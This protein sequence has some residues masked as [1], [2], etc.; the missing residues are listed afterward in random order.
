MEKLGKI[1][2]FMSFNNDT[3][4]KGFIKRFVH[5][6]IPGG[7]VAI[8]DTADTFGF[9]VMEKMFG[10]R[11]R[12]D[13][14]KFLRM[15]T[16]V[17]RYLLHGY[18]NSGR[19]VDIVVPDNG[20]L[21]PEVVASIAGF[22]EYVVVNIQ[23]VCPWAEDV[24]K[25]ADI[26][27]VFVGEDML[28]ALDKV[29]EFVI[30][31]NCLT[32]AVKVVIF[33]DNMNLLNELNVGIKFDIAGILSGNDRRGN[34]NETE[35]VV[36]SI[37]EA[38]KS[39]PGGNAA[40]FGELSSCSIPTVSMTKTITIG[41][42][43]NRVHM[44]LLE[45]EYKKSVH[46]KVLDALK[47]E[48]LEVTSLN[49]RDAA[50][51]NQIVNTVRSVVA[52]GGTHGV[53]LSSSQ[54]EGVIQ[55][56]VND[57]VGYGPLEELMVDKTVSE[58]MVNGIDRIYI[59]RNGKISLAAGVRFEDEQ[60]LRNV[61]D[62]IVA[63]AGRRVDDAVPLADARLFDGSRV[64]VVL[65]PLALNGPVV[66]IRRFMEHKLGV[67]QLVN[68]QSLD[69]NMASF[70]RACV[71]LKKNVV[72]S[73]GTGTGKTTLLNIV[74]S[75][76]PED[77]RIVSIEDSAEL[78]LPHEH[79]VRM[80]A[81]PANVEGKGAVSIRQ[82]VVNALRMR[83]DRIV[84]GECRGGEAFDMLQAMNTGHQGSLSTLHAN[85][86]R[87]ALARLETMVLMAGLDLPSIAIREQIVSAVDIVVQIRRM[88][89]G[90]RKVV[91]ITEVVGIESGT[92][93]TQDIFVYGNNNHVSTGIVPV[94]IDEIKYKCK[95]FDLGVFRDKQAGQVVTEYVIVMLVLLIIGLSAG[96]VFNTAAIKLW[97]MYTT[98]RTGIP[99][100]AP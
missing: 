84:I 58:I 17:S 66:T 82:L 3:R 43:D 47:R 16:E 20:C 73:G 59:E 81:R 100:L 9:S 23:P 48:N 46:N 45:V 61:I 26:L 76:I 36:A 65:P 5:K 51:N 83:P 70:L 32:S 18:F 19:E 4:E 14:S 31:E 30:K 88:A 15:K 8:V 99:G 50:V 86:P 54:R 93:Q 60:H 40:K 63:Q 2:A 87:D 11:E 1:V 79:W 72:I 24:F 33:S 53:S 55:R 7:S 49:L 56:V 35:G 68:I 67:A 91:C 21:L 52:E 25:I 94:F 44:D 12:K 85:T 41:M 95:W 6:L 90:A 38:V 74:S 57:I 96:A 64:N 62:R 75:F 42:S 22:Y 98:Y 69:N 92:I 89:D 13:V 29:Y 37:V 77:E 34:E 27:P 28:D 80:E 71:E 97:E 78:K 39:V 10:I